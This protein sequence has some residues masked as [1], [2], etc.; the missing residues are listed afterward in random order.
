MKRPILVVC[1]AIASGV[2]LSNARALAQW[3]GKSAGAGSV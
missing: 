3:V 2:I 1:L